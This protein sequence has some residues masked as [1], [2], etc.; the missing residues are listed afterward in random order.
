[1]KF[2]RLIVFFV[3]ITAILIPSAIQAQSETGEV[4]QSFYSKIIVNKDA[5]LTVTE[6]IDVNAVGDQIKHGIYRDFPTKYGLLSIKKVRFKVLSVKRDGQPI[7]YS[8]SNEINGKRI[9]LGDENIPIPPGRYSFELMYQTDHQLG[10]FPNHDELYWNATGNG[11]VFPILKASALVMLPPDIPANKM[12]TEGYTGQQGSKGQNYTSRVDS[13]GHAIFVSTAILPINNGL[14]IVVTWPKGYIRQ[15]TQKQEIISMLKGD[16]GLRYELIGLILLLIYYISIWI[17]VGKDPSKGSIMPLYEAPDGLSPAAVRY[18]RRMGFDQKCFAANLMDMA[19]KKMIR[20]DE[21]DGQFTITRG[22]YYSAVLS[23]EEKAITDGLLS[24]GNS[25]D[26]VNSNADQIGPAYDAVES[27]LNNKYQKKLFS[28]NRSLMVPG[29]VITILTFA[30][31]LYVNDPDLLLSAGLT[32]IFLPFWT[33]II[34]MLMSRVNHW[35]NV[36]KYGGGAIKVTGRIL[37]AIF[38]S[39]IFIAAVA[40]ELI[41]ISALALAVGPIFF[42]VMMGINL[43]FYK[44]LPVSTKEGRVLLDKIDG[45]CEYLSVAESDSL[46]MCKGPEITPALFEKH[47]PYAFAL[48]VEQEWSKKFADALEKAGQSYDEDKYTPKWYSGS[49]SG[50]SSGTFASSLG[51]SLSGAIS[52]SSTAPGSSSGSG[53]GGSSGGGG[54]G[55]GGGGF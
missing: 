32:T 46:E 2:S 13:S 39:L 11:W 22:K 8:L 21:V 44:L 43:I 20:I 19:V 10:F 49:M 36:V 50:F 29:V 7:P 17:H 55:G 30:A 14:T 42:F 47:L 18:I 3:I 51:G 25:I 1:M 26:L 5:S 12:K 48:G 35:W 24:K 45:L 34:S 31:M 38:L 54:G 23:G 4:I 41:M 33:F 6:T 28:T 9:Y 53:G 16:I 40:I 15:L 27:L 37:I 52:S